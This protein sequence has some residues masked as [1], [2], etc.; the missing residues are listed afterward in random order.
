MFKYSFSV[1]GLSMT[2]LNFTTHAQADSSVADTSTLNTI[3]VVGLRPVPK[4]ET[5]L[6]VS[7]IS[8]EELA[9]RSTPFLADQLRGVP[10]IAVSRSGS[11]SGLTQLRLRG[12]EA[13]HTLV[14]I[15]GIE[16]SDPTTGE[17][18]FGLISGLDIAQIEV[19]RGEQSGLYGSDAIGGVVNM[20]TASDEGL[21]GRFEYGSLDTTRLE[22]GYG[23]EH[24][25]GFSSVSASAFS[26]DGADVSDNAGE[27]DGSDGWSVLANGR[28]KLSEKWAVS[29]LA[30]YSE[31]EA[32]FD[33]DTDYDG[34]LNDV[35]QSSTTEQWLLAA[36]LAGT[37]LGVHHEFTASY[38]E[39]Q[40]ENFSSGASTDRSEGQRS[41]LSYSPSV[42]REFSNG[43]STRL[44]GLIDYEKEEYS[45]SDVQYFG[46]TKQDQSFET[47]GL[48]A[49][50]IAK[51][52]SLTLSGSLRY[53]DNDGRFDDATTGR[54]GVSYSTD[55]FGRFRASAGTGVKNP[56]F[57]ELFGFFPGS[58]VGNSNLQP[59]KST[60]W[61]IGWEKS[62]HAMDLTITYFEAELEDEIYT[63]FTPTFMST[64][65]NRIG[66]SKRSG[67]EIGFNWTATKEIEI[68]GQTT[69]TSSEADDGSDEIRV[70]SETASLSINYHPKNT[71]DFRFGAA[72]D[73]VG[74]QDD[75]NFS[76]Y[77]STRVTLDSYVLA[78]TSAEF[79]LNKKVSLTLRGENLLDQEVVDVFGYTSP[80][81]TAYIG[82]K[83]R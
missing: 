60:G 49:E 43:F 1:I 66:D 37:S 63:A 76:T 82:L 75:F 55:S 42:E 33:S 21:R 51:W 12:A 4:G 28:H 8:S 24:K 14:L 32:D 83:L 7:L 16:I 19:L 58:F 70:P 30:F 61:E 81:A 64:P 54:V 5:T 46:L 45:T 15:D 50:A 41:K 79:P 3:E 72:L 2:V 48:A 23:L 77:P 53:D 38:S 9:V 74:D 6:S 36:K 29:G 34:L 10:G 56:T 57:T 11:K 17:T 68:F 65:A 80:G 71:P 20:R 13:N 27:K 44:S 52:D 22:G 39:L 69:I 78:S 67:V 40:R 62:I 25:N 59:E 73:Y 26:T 31:T 47:I 18:N 35:D